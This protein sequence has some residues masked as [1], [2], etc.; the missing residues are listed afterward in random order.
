MQQGLVVKLQLTSHTNWTCGVTWSPSS[1]YN[2][3]SA[4]Y[5]GTVKVWDIR[6]STPLYSI[7]AASEDGQKVMAVDWFDGVIYSGGEDT[8]LRVHQCKI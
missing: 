6:S 8:Q 5:D 7:R 4:S 3:A 2:L 1:A